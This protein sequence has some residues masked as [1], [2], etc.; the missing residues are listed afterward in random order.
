[1]QLR[2]VHRSLT[3]KICTVMVPGGRYK[4]W[5]RRWFILNDNC[6]YY[7]EY[8]TDKE[9][10][11]IIPLENI[12]V[13]EVQDRHKPH[14]FELYAAGSE[15]IKACKTDSEGKVVEGNNQES[16]ILIDCTLICDFEEYSILVIISFHYYAFKLRSSK[17]YFLHF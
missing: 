7:F 4:S 15:F 5:K 10:R 9:P 2:I 11:G 8:T 17:K 16:W 3:F 12:Q 6:L 14:C 13:R 1:M